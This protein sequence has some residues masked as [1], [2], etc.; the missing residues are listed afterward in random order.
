MRER[1]E[2]GIGIVGAFLQCEQ[3]ARGDLSC[4]VRTHLLL[5]LPQRNLHELADL[6]CVGSPRAELA[7]KPKEKREKAEDACRG[8]MIRG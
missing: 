4:H 8:K 3:S 2:N 6:F 7:A 1:D 5:K